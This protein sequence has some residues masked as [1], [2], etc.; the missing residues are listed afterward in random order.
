MSNKASSGQGQTQNFLLLQA[1]SWIKQMSF[2]TEG[3]QL[4]TDIS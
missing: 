2:Q 1:K 4:Y 3:H